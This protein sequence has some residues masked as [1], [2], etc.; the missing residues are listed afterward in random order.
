MCVRVDI[1]CNT[2]MSSDNTTANEGE[3]EEAGCE[4]GDLHI[5]HLDYD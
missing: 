1:T 2:N 5:N 4:A 3:G